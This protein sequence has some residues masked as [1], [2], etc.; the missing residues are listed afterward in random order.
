MSAESHKTILEGYFS[1][2]YG[3]QLYTRFASVVLVA[4]LSIY[5]SVWAPGWAVAWSLAYLAGELSIIGW[6][7][8]V[9]G[10]IAAADEARL[11]R[12][13]TELIVLSTVLSNVAAL[14]CVFAPMSGLLPAVFGL[15]VASGCILILASQHSLNKTMFV[16]NAP[17]AAVGVVFSLYSIGHGL[18]A[19]IL[20]LL[21]IAFLI[22][23]FGLH[24]K[25]VI[26]LNELIRTKLDADS[27]NETKGAFLATIS[28][29]IR[30]PLN[31]VLG[32]TQA[33]EVDEL[34]P[35]QRERL[36]VVRQSG[37]ALLTI[38]NDVLDFSKIEAGKLA[39]ESIE[40]DLDEVA[41]G[42]QAT[43]AQQAVSKGLALVLDDGTAAGVYRGDPA[44]VRQ[45]LYNLI[46]NALKFTERGEVRVAI[47]YAEQRL[48]IEVRD[49][50]MG[51]A[52]DALAGLFDKFV[53]ADSSTTR[54]FGGTG[55][56][57]SICREL[58]AL[59]GGSI[60]A[61]SRVGEGSCFTV[62]LPLPRVADVTPGA[63]VATV[64]A[65][66]VHAERPVAAAPTSVRVLA[67][68]DNKVNQIVLKTLLGQ[69][70]LEP[71]VVDNGLEAV[72][73][74]EAE[75]WDV[76]LMDVQMPQMDGPTAARRIR[77]LE[78][79]AG[80]ARTPIVALT[81]NAM[82]HQLSEYRAAGMDAVVT[83]PIEVGKLFEALDAVLQ[84][85][86]N[87]DEAAA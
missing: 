65:H 7:R 81:A 15:V 29:E 2:T 4:G 27:A 1:R 43:F 20:A 18:S 74:W 12:L 70:G 11:R 86:A 34:S 17:T 84:P 78:A 47:A 67:A 26:S 33:M 6:W 3:E 75:S 85:A 66:P 5:F 64:L 45:I 44:R 55:L 50:G 32:M 41:R 87:P 24:S 69:I 62:I 28:H 48:R 53:Q 22:N 9:Q 35:R 58:A 83:K 36:G 46:S 16:A 73:A 37:E 25:N 68:E 52:P 13:H 63:P 59:M 76:I 21:G 57:L 8:A 56:G 54:R 23:A 19:W 10:K 14:P 51:I 72:A 82:A 60:E 80:R 30:T 71:R 49:T 31:G 38:L 79:A 77:V 42:A 40:F 61:A 39:L